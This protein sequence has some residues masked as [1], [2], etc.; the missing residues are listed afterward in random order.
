MKKLYFLLFTLVFT[1]SISAQSVFINEIHYDNTG[2][3][4][5]EFVEIAGP[6]GTDL[7]GWTVELY[8]GSNGSM[9]ATIALSGLIDDEG[10]GFGAVSFAGPGGGIQNGSPDGLA[11][12][13]N[14]GFVIQFLSYEGVLTATSGTANTMT[15]TD[16]GVSETGSTPVGESLQ[17]TN[18]PGSDY[19]DF[20]WTG[21]LT[22]SPG[23]LN[24]GQTFTLSVN[25]FEVSD[26]T[27]FPN[28]ATNG[29]V[30]IKTKNNQP[31]SVVAFDVLGKQ[32][33]NT[34]LST[35][36]LNLSNLKSGV[37]ILKL[38]QNGLTTTKKLVVQ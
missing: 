32:V 17:L 23:V 26:F 35:S 30:T 2:S 7:T 18:G 25:Q 11:L 38:S 1:V 4:V 24:T 15:S 33:I 20:T 6:A 13:D 19:S 3:D 34:V 22:E 28:P 27:V 5:G 37:Y 36:R 10:P 31:V 8:N 12:I 14:N 21:P 9:Y 16:I 29:F